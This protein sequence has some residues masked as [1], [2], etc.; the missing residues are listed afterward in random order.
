MELTA[1]SVIS[2]VTLII[3]FISKKLSIV[4]KKYIPLQNIVIGIISGFIVYFADIETGIFRS[5][6]LCLI[7]ALS[8]GGAYDALKVGG[9]KNK[10]E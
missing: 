2:L 1:F 8:A 6:V 9:D 5:I 4:D 3:G 10:D 7:G